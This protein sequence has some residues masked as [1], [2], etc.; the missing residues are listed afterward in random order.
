M[1]NFWIE[2]FNLDNISEVDDIDKL[3]LKNL[4][5]LKCINFDDMWGFDREGYDG[6]TDLENVNTISERNIKYDAS[7]MKIIQNTRL[8][9]KMSECS[10]FSAGN[11]LEIDKIP[12]LFLKKKNL[13]IIKNVND[14]KCLLW[15]YIRKN[16]NPIVKNI[17]R[18]NK[19]DIQ[20]S[21]ELIDE[22]NIDFEN[23]SKSEIGKI[24]DI[25]ECNI[26][27][28]G[29]NRNSNNKKIIKKSLKDYD[30]DLDLLLINEIN[31]YILIKNINLFIGNNSHILK[32]FRN[33]FNVFYSEEKYKFHIEYCKNRKPKKL[34]PSFKKYMFFEN[35]KNCIKTNWIIQSDF[36][37]VIDPKTK[38]HEFISGGFY[39]ECKNKKYSKDIQ[40][41][42]NLEEYTKNLYNEL[43]YIEE[44]E[45]NYLQNPIDYS[46]FD[47]KN[48]IM[49]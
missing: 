41:F 15:C 35:L 29:C 37:C 20:I 42:Y 45:E 10:L 28:F 17:S 5:N 21:K 39:I 43:K 46:N 8:V 47:E 13:V 3:N 12:E 38:E 24:E 33:C 32:S 19:K 48:V 30:K 6:T 27:V 14:S 40:T 44:I 1:T 36:E 25:L 4:K 16:L 22:H 7:Q 18:I 11:S 49:F 31:H 34:L 9:V 23:I 26:Y 2:R